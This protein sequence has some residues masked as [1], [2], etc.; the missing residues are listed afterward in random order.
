MQKITNKIK[1]FKIIALILD[2]IVLLYF[3]LYV[4]WMFGISDIDTNPLSH[5]FLTINPMT[6]GVY[7]LGAAMLVHLMAYK[8]ILSRC[9]IFLPYALSTTASTVSLIAMTGWRD[10]IIF[11]PHIFIIAAAV[12]II[13]KQQRSAK[14]NCNIP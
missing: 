13:V 14:I 10:L 4:Y 6:T 7:C 11:I 3:S 5:L 1:A 12:I 8:N 2:T 9:I